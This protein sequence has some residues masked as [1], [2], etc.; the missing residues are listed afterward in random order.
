M[1]FIKK[2][3]DFVLLDAYTIELQRLNK[4]WEEFNNLV[5]ENKLTIGDILRFK[6]FVDSNKSKHHKE[7]YKLFGDCLSIYIK[8]FNS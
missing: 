4:Q 3:F 7:K 5:E 1:K 6:D 2:L 8:N